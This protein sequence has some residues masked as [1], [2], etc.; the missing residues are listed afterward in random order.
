MSAIRL[1]LFIP[2]EY[3]YFIQLFCFDNV[4]HLAMLCTQN[5]I[6]S[7]VISAKSN[8]ASTSTQI[9]KVTKSIS[10]VSLNFP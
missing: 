2:N 10:R 7:M 1:C 5:K 4:D 9:S 3:S 6:Y 8:T